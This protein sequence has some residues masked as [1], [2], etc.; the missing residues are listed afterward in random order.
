MKSQFLCSHASSVCFSPFLF[1]DCSL[2][3]GPFYLLFVA[4]ELQLG[5][6]LPTELRAKVTFQWDPSP[7]LYG[8][9]ILAV[10]MQLRFQIRLQALSVFCFSHSL[11]ISRE[12]QTGHLCDLLYSTAHKMSPSY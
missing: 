2:T 5:E 8:A 10:A 3:C 1:W 6:K 11:G 4:A 12:K 7:S 9:S